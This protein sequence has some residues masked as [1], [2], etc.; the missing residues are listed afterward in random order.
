MNE[1]NLDFKFIVINTDNSTCQ[2]NCHVLEQ[3]EGR[4]ENWW[5]KE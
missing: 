1:H 2:Y 5:K 4:D 3:F